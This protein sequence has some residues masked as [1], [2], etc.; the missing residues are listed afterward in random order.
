MN[1]IPFLWSWRMI[2]IYLWLKKKKITYGDIN[3]KDAWEEV[4]SSIK[5]YTLR[6]AILFYLKKTKPTGFAQ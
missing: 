1:R 6:I 5:P 2:K 3:K 4:K